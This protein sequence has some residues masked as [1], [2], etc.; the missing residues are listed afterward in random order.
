MYDCTRRSDGLKCVLKQVPLGGLSAIDRRDTLNEASIL[1]SVQSPHVVAYI[2]SWEDSESD[3]LYIV[4]EHA[5]EDLAAVM[6]ESGGSLSE[7]L[8]WDYLVQVAQ[9]LAHLHSLRVLHRD[10]KPANIFRQTR[11]DFAG[12]VVIGDLGLGRV[13]G[14]NSDFA[15]TGVGTPLYFSPELC[16][17]RP[18]NNKSDVWALGCL[19]FELVSGVPPFTAQNQVALAQKI[20]DSPPARLPPHVTPELAFVVGQML[21]K[22]PERRPSVADVLQLSCVRARAERTALRRSAAAEERSM[23]RRYADLEASLRAELEAEREAVTREVLALDAMRNAVE[24]AADPEEVAAMSARIGSLESSNAVLAARLEETEARLV[25]S[26]RARAALA[27]KLEAALSAAAA[28]RAAVMTPYKSP[29]GGRRAASHVYDVDTP[30]DALGTP[31]GVSGK[32]RAAAAAARGAATPSPGKGRGGGGGGGGGFGSSSSSWGTRGRSPA[33]G[34][35][36]SP[37][38]AA[39]ALPMVPASPPMVPASPPGA[40]PEKPRRVTS[41]GTTPAAMDV[42]RAEA[43]ATGGMT[44]TRGSPRKPTDVSSRL[45]V[46]SHDE[47]VVVASETSA[48]ADAQTPGFGDEQNAQTPGFGDEQNVQT[49]GF[50]DDETCGDTTARP[51]RVFAS[52]DLP[53]TDDEEDGTGGEEAR[54]GP[55]AGAYEGRWRA[56]GSGAVL[57]PGDS[58][59]HWPAIAGDIGVG[60]N[61]GH[62]G[63]DGGGGGAQTRWGGDG[64]AGVGD[65]D[66]EIGSAPPSP[67]SPAA[68][69]ANVLL[70]AS[71]ESVQRSADIEAA[72][73][74]AARAVEVGTVKLLSPEADTSMMQEAVA[75]AAAKAAMEPS[76]PPIR[77]NDESEKNPQLVMVSAPEPLSRRNTARSLDY[78]GLLTPRDSCHSDVLQTPREAV[79][80]ETSASFLATPLGSPIADPPRVSSCALSPSLPVSI[81]SEA[82]K[83]EA[84]ALTAAAAD[85]AGATQPSPATSISS[86]P[87]IRPR[88]TS[89][90]AGALSQSPI[91]S[92]EGEWELTPDERRA[93]RSA[94]EVFNAVSPIKPDPNQVSCSSEGGI[95]DKVED[96]TMRRDE[97]AL[98]EDEEYDDEDDDERLFRSTS[99]S[100]I[101]TVS[102]ASSFRGSV[103]VTTS[104]GAVTLKDGLVLSDSLRGSGTAPRARVH[105][106]QQ[107]TASVQHG[108]TVGGDCAID[109]AALTYRPS[110]YS[111]LGTPH[112]PGSAAPNLARVSAH[113]A[114]ASSPAAAHDDTTRTAAGAVAASDKPASSTPRLVK[115]GAV[116]NAEVLELDV[117]TGWGA[118]GPPFVALHAWKR[119]RSS[120]ARASTPALE[121]DITRASDEPLTP[122]PLGTTSRVWENRKRVALPATSHPAYMVLYRVTVPPMAVPSP[123]NNTREAAAA[124]AEAAAAAVAC[125]KAKLRGSKARGDAF[126][127][128]VLLPPGTS[129]ASFN[130]GGEVKT[131]TRGSSSGGS[132]SR[133]LP[134]RPG[135]LP[136]RCVE[137]VPPKPPGGKGGKHPDGAWVELMLEFSPAAAVE[138]VVVIK[139]DVRLA[140]LAAGGSGAVPRIPSTPRAGVEAHATAVSPRGGREGAPREEEAGAEAFVVATP[141]PVRKGIT[142]SESVVAYETPRAPVHVGAWRARTASAH[143]AKGPGGDGGGGVYVEGH[144]PDGPLASGF[145]F[146]PPTSERDA[147]C[148]GGALDSASASAT[149]SHRRRPGSAAARGAKRRT[150][151]PSKQPRLT[152]K[153][154]QNQQQQQRRDERQ[155]EAVWPLK[156][157]QVAELLRRAQNTPP[158]AGKKENVP[159]AASLTAGVEPREA[160]SPAW[161]Q[162]DR[163]LVTNLLQQAEMLQRAV[164]EAAERLATPEASH[165]PPRPSHAFRAGEAGAPAPDRPTPGAAVRTPRSPASPVARVSHASDDHSVSPVAPRPSGAATPAVTSS[166]DSPLGAET[167]SRWN[168]PPATCGGDFASATPG[169]PLRHQQIPASVSPFLRR[170]DD[171]VGERARSRGAGVASACGGR[172]GHQD[173]GAGDGR[174]G[175]WCGGSPEAEARRHYGGS[176]AWNESTEEPDESHLPVH[177]RGGGRMRLAGVLEPRVLF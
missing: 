112:V 101:H 128:C 152:P 129:S 103:R 120:A 113:T 28:E 32:E 77:A 60:S 42:R 49:P 5:G 121:D 116:L 172:Y 71:L 167:S 122:S 138:E 4:M 63:T 18:Y 108:Q 46:P 159:E 26:E 96:T 139:A 90:G 11:G 29:S 156:A 44:H 175:R 47:E 10:L 99:A 79:A 146:T 133:S 84:D 153:Q 12:A 13:L 20:V 62:D 14:T 92:H 154:E 76:P 68:A 89:T 65:G 147:G 163:A 170:A 85:V 33:V 86:S 2:D 94:D 119:V 134:T 93:A 171:V 102:A 158:K 123:G 115:G 72:R 78:S 74:S 22:D 104:G 131:K 149:P 40:T 17:E 98:R 66:D 45:A 48:A 64:S 126:H 55:R 132:P 73:A 34:T 8:V 70:G 168:T 54:A 140:G 15:K 127:P 97:D 114:L 52:P 82:A 81:A 25:D 51:P 37:S 23:R 53:E 31:G 151:T 130:P 35:H 142:G 165:G 1:R 111:S 36:L 38:T 176:A 135:V 174:R 67:I 155:H 169:A 43:K 24:L 143:S 166:M 141:S 161:S 160:P 145:S 150:P 9:G 110:E 69:E 144:S 137:V 41:V 19:V 118:G 61:L 83:A 30:G 173:T 50:G 3:C 27:V 177:G 125:K 80:T 59:S 117:P 105:D 148:S 58:W 157:N 124:A 95:R 88:W 109:T 106:E 75:E 91:A 56:R 39:P 16:Q 21:A 136:W 6:R 162:Q 107:S 164:S 7:E 87:Q 100:T 57:G